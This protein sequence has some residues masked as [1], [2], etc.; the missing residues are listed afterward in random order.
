MPIK[1]NKNL[2]P[3]FQVFLHLHM[4]AAEL[5]ERILCRAWNCKPGNDPDLM[6]DR[7][8]YQ[9]LESGLKQLE[10]SSVSQET[11]KETH[12]LFSKVKEAVESAIRQVIVN[13]EMKLANEAEIQTLKRL[14]DSI[15]AITALGALEGIIEECEFV[16]VYLGMTVSQ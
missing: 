4:E 11:R 13:A 12:Q 10:N 14:A 3:D 8:I 7:K 6:A 16:F 9:R 1:I 2:N 15:Q 5:Y